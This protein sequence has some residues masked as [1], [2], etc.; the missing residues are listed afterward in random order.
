MVIKKTHCENLKPK[1]FFYKYSQRFKCNCKQSNLVFF[2][3]WQFFL[4]PLDDNVSHDKCDRIEKKSE[5]SI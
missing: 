2:I 1:S 3:T 4:H 5:K